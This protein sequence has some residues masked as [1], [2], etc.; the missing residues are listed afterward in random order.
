MF[1]IRILNSE[2]NRVLRLRN[3]AGCIGTFLRRLRGTG[4]KQ[5]ASRSL[6]QTSQQKTA[7]SVHSQ[8]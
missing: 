7:L 2:R 6:L 4:L 3:D 5:S 8:A 1:E